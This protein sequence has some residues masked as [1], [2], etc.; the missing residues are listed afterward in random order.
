V[1]RVD[2]QETEFSTKKSFLVDF[3]RQQIL[4]ET[5]TSFRILE[6]KLGRREFQD[7]KACRRFKE[8]LM[9]FEIKQET[10]LYRK[11]KVS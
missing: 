1:E 11:F 2:S 8:D 3:K 9:S 10:F 7:I 5:A 6:F 4:L